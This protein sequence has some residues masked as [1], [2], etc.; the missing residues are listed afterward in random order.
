MIR[1]TNAQIATEL[2]KIVSETPKERARRIHEDI[3]EWKFEGFKI[4]ESRDI[5]AFYIWDD[6]GYYKVVPRHDLT[7]DEFHLILRTTPW[8]YV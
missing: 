4:Q 2:Y 1:P 3:H 8:I 5:L 7:A 6:E